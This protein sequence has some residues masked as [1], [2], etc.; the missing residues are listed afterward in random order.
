MCNLS[1]MADRKCQLELFLNNI[2][3]FHFLLSCNEMSALMLYCL[4]K[5]M[6]HLYRDKR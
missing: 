3:E 5:Q 2:S 6:Y 4:G 1:V